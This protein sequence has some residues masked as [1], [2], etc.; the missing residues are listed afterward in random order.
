MKANK[1]KCQAGMRFVTRFV[2]LVQRDDSNKHTHVQIQ[3]HIQTHSY[4]RIY[5]LIHSHRH[6]YIHKL[7]FTHIH[8]TLTHS[9]SPAHSCI[10]TLFCTCNFFLLHMCIIILN[11][12]AY[13]MIV[14][15]HA[16]KYMLTHT[17][18]YSYHIII[19]TSKCPYTNLKPQKY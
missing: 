19:Y 7:S 14:N 2:F 1:K 16:Y 4:T 5:T 9:W 18:I 6:T 10:H 15:L 3:T 12:S 17:Y 8:I 13:I 11:V